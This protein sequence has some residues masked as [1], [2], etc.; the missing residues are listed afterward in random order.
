M[1]AADPL[2]DAPD[3]RAVRSALDGA[4]LLVVQ[5]A[6]L[7]PTAAR[8]DV[9]L[10][11]AV[12]GEE[13]GSS[14]NLAGQVG[15]HRAAIPPLGES[16][17]HWRIL[18]GLARRLGAPGPWDYASAADVLA[19]IA[20]VVPAYA[21]AP[22]VLDAG[23]CDARFGYPAAASAPAT[24][25]PLTTVGTG[26][27]ILVTGPVLFDRDVLSRHAPAIVARAPE[28][29]VE[30]NSGD[31]AG[32]GIE[33]GDLVEVRG[34]GGLLRRRARVSEDCL[35]G[36]VFVPEDLGPESVNVLGARRGAVALVDV[37]PAS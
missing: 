3:P 11:A 22:A 19:E 35:A 21:G 34:E 20:R 14:T 28:P 33:A 16:R 24:P 32:L 30:L 2:S 26:S 1:L 37:K 15:W 29:Y 25:G 13:D 10:P 9:V 18:A 31:A 27:L 12:P 7:T 5:D 23:R 36:T 8:A 4:D 17:P 6:F